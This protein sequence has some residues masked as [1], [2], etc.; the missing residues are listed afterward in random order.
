[1]VLPPSSLII[2][3][4]NLTDDEIEKLIKE[5]A[6][7]PHLYIEKRGKLQRPTKEKKILEPD[8]KHYLNVEEWNG[9]ERLNIS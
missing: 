1:M 9:G 3:M 6:K 5:V 8:S 2:N 4:A 7:Y